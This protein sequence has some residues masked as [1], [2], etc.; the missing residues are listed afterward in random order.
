MTTEASLFGLTDKKA[1]VIGGGQ[2]VGESK[3]H[4]LARAGCDV[5]VI[6]QTVPS[7]GSPGPSRPTAMARHPT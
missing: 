6:A 5:A 4:F 3:S 1:M 7:A 2:S